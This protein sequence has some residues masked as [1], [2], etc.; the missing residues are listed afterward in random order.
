MASAMLL[1]ARECFLAWCVVIYSFL[2]RPLH[3]ACL[4]L[5]W[6]PKEVNLQGGTGW[7]SKQPICDLPFLQLGGVRTWVFGQASKPPQ[8]E[9]SLLLAG[10]NSGG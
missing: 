9:L 4:E 7:F 3:S 1:D 10:Y 6:L 2:K 5:G 8:V